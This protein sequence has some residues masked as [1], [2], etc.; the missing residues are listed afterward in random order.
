[1]SCEKTPSKAEKKDD[2]KEDEDDDI[3]LFSLS[4]KKQSIRMSLSSDPRQKTPKGKLCDGDSNDPFGTS[5]V[6]QS[7]SPGL[8]KVPDVVAIEQQNFVSSLPAADAPLAH[9]DYL[10]EVYYCCEQRSEVPFS[11]YH[12]LCGLPFSCTTTA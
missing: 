11:R 5:E 6:T 3:P 4:S 9:L 7:T 10:S 12:L 2:D 1:L 8:L